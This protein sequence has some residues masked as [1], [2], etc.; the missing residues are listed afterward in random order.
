MINI[1]NIW[2]PENHT[3]NDSH[4]FLNLPTTSER[5][6]L[7]VTRRTMECHAQRVTFVDEKVLKKAIQSHR[8]LFENSIMK[9]MWIFMLKYGA[10]KTV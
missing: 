6:A 3:L 1:Q 8:Y 4:E 5:N 9:I 7:S 10:L 2:A